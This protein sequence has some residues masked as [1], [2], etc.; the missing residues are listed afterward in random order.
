MQDHRIGMPFLHMKQQSAVPCLFLHRRCTWAPRDWLV[1]LR[2]ARNRKSS[3]SGG[4]RFGVGSQQDSTWVFLLPSS[5]L[6]QVRQVCGEEAAEYLNLKSVPGSARV[7]DGVGTEVIPSKSS[8]EPGGD[9][10]SQI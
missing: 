8:E 10:A 6:L 3:R 9:L 4:A 2:E 7:L 5:C 1:I